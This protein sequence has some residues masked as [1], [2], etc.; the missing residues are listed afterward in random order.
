MHAI[1]GAREF[2]KALLEKVRR[3]L[4]F[5]LFTE[6]LQGKQVFIITNNASKTTTEY[7]AKISELGFNMLEEVH[8]EAIFSITIH[9]CSRIQVVFRDTV[10]C[11][12][13]DVRFSRRT[14]SPL[15]SF[16]WIT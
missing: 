8:V 3:N 6:N 4:I 5:K 1:P 15:T 11:C 13:T 2:L 12:V 10:N 9:H 16:S 14:S 7:V